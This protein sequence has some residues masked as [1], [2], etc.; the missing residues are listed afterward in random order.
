MYR[1]PS[2]NIRHYK[3][4][5]ILQCLVGAP[6]GDTRT[7]RLTGT[8][9]NFKRI[10]TTTHTTT[11]AESDVKGAIVCVCVTVVSCPVPQRERCYITNRL[12]PRCRRLQFTIYVYVYGV[13]T[14]HYI[15]Y[16]RAFD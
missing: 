7:R 12:Q 2:L 15:I 10:I 6:Q 3:V 4:H 1:G 13:L 5:V 16:T 14:R 9:I 11:P 8:Q